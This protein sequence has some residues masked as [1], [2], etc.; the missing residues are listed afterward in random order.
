[1]GRRNVRHKGMEQFLAY[2]EQNGPKT[3]QEWADFFGI[4]RSHFN[5]VRNR[6]TPAGRNLIVTIAK[7]TG[8]QVPITAWFEAVE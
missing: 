8:G 3:D 7:K 6:K 5:M 1:M 4:S 2:I